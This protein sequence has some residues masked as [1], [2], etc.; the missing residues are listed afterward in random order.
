[1][2]A[3]DDGGCVD[4][5]APGPHQVGGQH[6]DD[7]EFALADHKRRVSEGSAARSARSRLGSARPPCSSHRHTA[8]RR[9]SGSGAS[10]A[11]SSRAPITACRSCCRQWGW[12]AES[13]EHAGTVCKIGRRSAASGRR[14]S[15]AAVDLASGVGRRRALGGLGAVRGPWDRRGGA[16]GLHRGERASKASSTPACVW[17]WRALSELAGVSTGEICSLMSSRCNE[18]ASLEQ[19]SLLRVLRRLH[20]PGRCRARARA[21]IRHSRVSPQTPGGRRGSNRPCSRLP[22]VSGH[23]SCL[24]QAGPC[25][26]PSAPPQMAAGAGKA[27]AAPA[28]PGA[29]GSVLPAAAAAVLDDSAAPTPTCE[30]REV[31]DRWWGWGLRSEACRLLALQPSA[32]RCRLVRGA[33]PLRAVVAC[34]L[35]PCC[36]CPL[37]LHGRPLHAPDLCHP[38]LPCL[39]PH[40]KQLFDSLDTDGNGRLELGDLQ[41]RPCRGRFSVDSF[42]FGKE[43][44]PASRRR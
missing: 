43:R 37:P 29:A 18:G 21:P 25:C 26:T 40:R 24:L 2:L 16:R 11:R 12:M 39:P 15:P 5:A 36:M 35:P 14:R 41:A 32:A 1:M 7:P 19:P 10:S 44:R 33:G 6:Q 42:P 9:S 4:K 23:S 8:S 31:R 27:P 3:Q 20:L 13:T 28:A 30:L 34:D 22:P 38:C 17:G